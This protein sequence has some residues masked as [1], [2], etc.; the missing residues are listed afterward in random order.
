MQLPANQQ[1]SPL[2]SSRVG[3]R[4]LRS[5]LGTSGNSG[6]QKSRA[7]VNNLDQLL[8]NESTRGG[9]TAQEPSTNLLHS[10]ISQLHNSSIS[11]MNSSSRSLMHSSSRSLM[12]SSHHT[13]GR[14]GIPT[15]PSL[16]R[17]SKQGSLLGDED[18]SGHSSVEFDPRGGPMNL[19]GRR[20]PGMDDSQSTFCYDHEDDYVSAAQPPQ[21][22][23]EHHAA[24]PP[25]AAATATTEHKTLEELTSQAQDKHQQ[26]DDENYEMEIAPG[27][28][29]PFR[30]ANEV[31][32]AVDN[33]STLECICLECGVELVSV[34][35]CEHVVCPEENC[36]MVNPVFEHPPGV[37]QVYGAGLGFKKDWL[38]QEK[39][40]RRSALCR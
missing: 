27:F 31:W 6:H 37:T 25:A 4:G 24:A 32:R 33:N 9:S 26:Q 15:V 40:R 29:V 21:P 39:R 19:Y 28:Y 23:S 13:R 3:T 11:Q 22:P 12:Q 7:R 30:G 20:E 14:G 16:G 5:K 18:D 1:Q 2:R 36:R 34:A 35:D 17:P 38:L 8:K 10:S